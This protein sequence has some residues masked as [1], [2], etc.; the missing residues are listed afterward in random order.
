MSTFEIK[1]LYETAYN[2]ERQEYHEQ[3]NLPE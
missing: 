1:P 3:L 2:K